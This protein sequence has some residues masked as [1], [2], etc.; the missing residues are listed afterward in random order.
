M[1]INPK[2]N[3]MAVVHTTAGSFTMDLFASQDPVAV[4]NFVFLSNQHFYDGDK[5]F[6]VLPS[7]VIQTGDPNNNGTGGPG[8]TWSAELPVPFPYQPG[9]V[10]MAVSDNNPNTNGSQFFICT[11]PQ[12]VQ[13]NQD[14][15]YTEV[16]RIVKGWSTI[17]T[18][19]KGP[20]TVNPVTNEKSYPVHPYTITGIT[21][22]VSAPSS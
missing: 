14:P 15:I 16:G 12:S 9:I 17:D 18:I 13:L 5:F 6:R 19:E 21:I 22:N 3:Y 20:V 10:A 1:T 4:N 8:Y 7:F 2:D 11:G